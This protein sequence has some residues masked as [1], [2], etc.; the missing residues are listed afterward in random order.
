MDYVGVY[1][2]G[3]CGCIYMDY[4]GVYR[5]YIYIWTKWG[6][7]LGAA[8]LVVVVEAHGEVAVEVHSDGTLVVGG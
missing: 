1:I 5:V 3:L 8:A 7:A 6:V 2:Y 4:V